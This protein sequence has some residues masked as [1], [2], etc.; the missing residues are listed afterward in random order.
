MPP[1]P[2]T[3][4][5]KRRRRRRGA[6]SSSPKRCAKPPRVNVY[7]VPYEITGNLRELRSSLQA[8]RELWNNPDAEFTLWQDCP[9][10]AAPGLS[11]SQFALV[12]FLKR[13]SKRYLKTAAGSALLRAAEEK[14]V[15]SAGSR[16]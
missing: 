14:R 1:T 11:I 7:R 16:R 13:H 10:V 8:I 3:A 15:S 12:F 9:G 5:R 4:R 6:S 2:T